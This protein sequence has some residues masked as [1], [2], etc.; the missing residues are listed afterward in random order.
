M[1][2]LPNH[3]LSPCGTFPPDALGREDNTAFLSSPPPSFPPLL[4]SFSFSLS[5]LLPPHCPHSN[6]FSNS[7]PPLLPPSASLCASSLPHTL[8]PY[9]IFLIPKTPLLPRQQSPRTP[10][11]RIFSESLERTSLPHPQLEIV[12]TFLVPSRHVPRGIF[13]RARRCRPPPGSPRYQAWRPSLPEAPPVAYQRCLLPLRQ[14]EDVIDLARERGGAG[15]QEPPWWE[16][17]KKR[18]ARWKRNKIPCLL[19]LFCWS[20]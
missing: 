13:G 10:K 7:F 6:S 9:C 18:T 11:K 5:P 16:A 14:C 20:C 15:W 4:P 8:A 3:S 19:N 2:I 1:R 12:G 17:R